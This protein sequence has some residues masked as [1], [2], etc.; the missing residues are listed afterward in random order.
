ML[1]DST[2]GGQGPNNQVV[3]ASRCEHLIVR[4]E[5]HCAQAQT[6]VTPVRLA[7][8]RG[9]KHLLSVVCFETH[10]QLGCLDV[11]NQDLAILAAS[12]EHRVL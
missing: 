12:C 4:A 2:L 1:D 6:T 10:L 3:Y 7:T 9:D 8:D 5:G 11:E